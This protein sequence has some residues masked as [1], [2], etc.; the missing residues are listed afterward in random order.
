MITV[1]MS[2]QVHVHVPYTTGSVPSVL[3]SISFSLFSSVFTS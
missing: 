2:V 1:Y 3:L